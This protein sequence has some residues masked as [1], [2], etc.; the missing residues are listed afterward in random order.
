MHHTGC[1]L[2]C[3]FNAHDHVIIRSCIKTAEHL[4]YNMQIFE[5]LLFATITSKHMPKAYKRCPKVMQD[6]SAK[7]ADEKEI[8]EKIEDGGG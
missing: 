6:G 3:H 2:D 7:M 5:H 8:E 4:K 1:A